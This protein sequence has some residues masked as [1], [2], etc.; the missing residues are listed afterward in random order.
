[1]ALTT[2]AVVLLVVVS[3]N[4]GLRGNIRAYIRAEISNSPLYDCDVNI[5]TKKK[6]NNKPSNVFN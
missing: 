6:N 1:M 2:A 5:D 3:P 4:I